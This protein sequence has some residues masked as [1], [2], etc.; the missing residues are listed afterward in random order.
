[1]SRQIDISNPESLSEDDRKY[2]I[3]RG[4][5]QVLNQVDYIARVDAA[6]AAAL[7]AQESEPEVVVEEVDEPYEK[8]KVDDLR[9]EC[10]ARDLS[11]EGSKADLVARLEA[12]DAE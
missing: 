7:A 11:D 4:R 12:N 8:W 1:M 3:Q 9:N 10:R 2:L 6:R 5:T